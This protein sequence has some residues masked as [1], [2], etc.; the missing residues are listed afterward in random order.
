M[1][2]LGNNSS[3]ISKARWPKFRQPLG[4]PECLARPEVERLERD[5]KANGS[6]IKEDKKSKATGK[7]TTSPD[8]KHMNKEADEYFD[9]ILPD[10]LGII[11]SNPALIEHYMS[12]Q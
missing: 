1:G 8:K 12:P 2:H 7:T 10:A 11:A 3:G 5:D 6:D 4:C 9:K